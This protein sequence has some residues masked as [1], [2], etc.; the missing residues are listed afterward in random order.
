MLPLIES[1][2]SAE[3]ATVG[4]DWA[5]RARR[6]AELH[7]RFDSLFQALRAHQA[8][9]TVVTLAEQASNDSQAHAQSY[10]KLASAF[11]VHT[12]IGD[13]IR[14]GPLAPSGLSILERIIYELVQLSCVEETLTGSLVGRIYQQAKHPQI[15]LTAHLA[16]QDEIW[17]SRLGWAHLGNVAN[18]VSVAWL[19]AH[20]VEMLERLKT[21]E[22]YKDEVLGVSST[23]LLA[24]G[25]LGREQ[26]L[27]LLRDGI[28]TIIL[29]GFESFGIDVTQARQWSESML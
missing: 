27:D 25:V 12:D 19:S 15:R 10:R 8:T 17:H 26:R 1:L 20:V 3:K 2:T 24:Y 11:G 21:H 5:R 9:P 18:Q 22:L 28:N 29:P 7:L 16:F 4:E 13:A 6:E 23:K 14:L